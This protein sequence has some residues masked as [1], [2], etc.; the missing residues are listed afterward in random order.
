MHIRKI[1]LISHPMLINKQISSGVF[2]YGGW[3]MVQ[4]TILS[5]DNN[6]F[7]FLFSPYFFNLK[8]ENAPAKLSF[9]LS[10]RSIWN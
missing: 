8:V 1:T 7:F 4:L 5:Y 10:L 6:W 3:R 9:K 2:V